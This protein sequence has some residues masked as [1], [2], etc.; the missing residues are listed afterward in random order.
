M[1]PEHGVKLGSKY[2]KEVGLYIDVVFVACSL[3]IL[4][5]PTKYILQLH[6]YK[7]I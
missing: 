2:L 3:C 7:R 1:E 5:I 4:I 6:I